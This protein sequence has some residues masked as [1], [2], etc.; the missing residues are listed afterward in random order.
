MSRRREK[1]HYF[2]AFIVPGNLMLALRWLQDGT[3]ESPE[4]IAR[5]AGQFIN[6][7]VQSFAGR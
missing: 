4:E 6:S 3:R 7:G 5:F 1:I 2:C